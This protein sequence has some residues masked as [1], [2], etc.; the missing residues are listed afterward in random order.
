MFMRLLITGTYML[1]NVAATISTHLI[2]VRYFKVALLEMNR[3]QLRSGYKFA[4]LVC[5]TSSQH[6]VRSTKLP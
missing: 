1:L 6:K 5:S 2:P 4:E 3:Y